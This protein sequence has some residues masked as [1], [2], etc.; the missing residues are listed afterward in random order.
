MGFNIRDHFIKSTRTLTEQEK[1]LK[2]KVEVLNNKINLKDSV[3]KACNSEINVS[4]QKLDD[5]IKTNHFLLF[6]TTFLVVILLASLK[7]KKNVS[8]KNN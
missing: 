3:I 7:F 8:K 5:I 4:Q 2:D 1:L 6:T